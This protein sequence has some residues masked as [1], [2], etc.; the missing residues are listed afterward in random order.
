M[1]RA[2]QAGTLDTVVWAVNLQANASGGGALSLAGAAASPAFGS[3]LL[4]GDFAGHVA[5]GAQ[6]LTSSG[7]TDAFAAE[8]DP[9]SGCTRAL[10]RA[11]LDAVCLAVSRMT[12][13]GCCSL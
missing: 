1:R 9:D 11:C 5:F 10:P 12:V 4:A 13:G 3:L 2:S 8:L 6:T 7:G